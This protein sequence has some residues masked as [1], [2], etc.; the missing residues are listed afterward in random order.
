MVTCHSN[1]RFSGK[2]TVAECRIAF[3]VCCPERSGI[4]YF[5]GLMLDPGQDV[6]EILF[7]AKP[8]PLANLWWCRIG[9]ERIT[10]PEPPLPAGGAGVARSAAA[11]SVRR[12]VCSR[13]ASSAAA[14]RYRLRGYAP[15]L[16]VPAFVATAALLAIRPSAQVRT[17]TGYRATRSRISTV[18]TACHLG[19]SGTFASISRRGRVGRGKAWPVQAAGARS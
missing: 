4:A 11:A 14:R 10:T 17:R 13:G 7:R 1:A 19:R 6:P 16:L 5:D 12:A 18:R 9:T 2:V 15:A 8:S 3:A